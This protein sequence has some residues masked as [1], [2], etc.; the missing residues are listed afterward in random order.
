M[1][2]RGHMRGPAASRASRSTGGVKRATAPRWDDSPS[3][4][5]TS[6]RPARERARL[7]LA[8]TF[9]GPSS[10]VA[11]RVGVL[12]ALSV[13]DSPRRQRLSSGAPARSSAAC[14]ASTRCGRA[15]ASSQSRAASFTGSPITVY[16]KRA[17]LPTFPATATGRHADREALWKLGGEP[18][19]SSRPAASASLAGR[20]RGTGAPK[21]QSAASP[22][23]FDLAA[24][25]LHDA[26]DH[27]EEGVQQ[28]HHLARRLSQASE[29]EPTRS[30]N[31]AAISRSSPSGARSPPSAGVPRHG[32][33]GDRRGRE[34][35][36]AQPGPGR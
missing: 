34:G 16:S 22:L 11:S 8:A 13:T 24:V 18:P 25:G 32:P 7:P 2:R 35:A 17:S 26:H 10:T 5:A 3:V 9:P 28:A 29:V 27:A 33:R 1:C 4:R 19:P 36:R 21:T 31:R 14:D 20:S 15:L 30:M 12:P 6:L 23:E